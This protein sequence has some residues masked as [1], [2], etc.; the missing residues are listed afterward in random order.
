MT[1]LVSIE[2]IKNAA[3]PGRG[4]FLLNMLYR[5]EATK[6]RR[7]HRAMQSEQNLTMGSPSRTLGLWGFLQATLFVM[8]M[9]KALIHLND[10]VK[11]SQF[12]HA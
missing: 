3:T 1:V 8:N 2:V 9:L 6:G 12:D 5:V 4:G 10:A 11:Q 7:N